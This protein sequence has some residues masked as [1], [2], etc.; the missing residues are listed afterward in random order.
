MKKTILAAILAAT[1]MNA[2][3]GGAVISAGIYKESME[4][5]IGESI[6]KGNRERKLTEVKVLGSTVFRTYEMEKSIEEIRKTN[7]IRGR[8]MDKFL[9]DFKEDQTEALCKGPLSKQV[10]KKGGEIVSIYKLPKGATL[11]THKLIKCE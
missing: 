9:S 8:N 7:R 4:K 11:M 5:Q 10:M 2:V 6:G 1:S 3:A